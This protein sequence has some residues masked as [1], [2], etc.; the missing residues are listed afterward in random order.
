LA[1]SRKRMQYEWAEE[2]A[3]LK[4]RVTE[5]NRQL[6]E[7]RRAITFPKIFQKVAETRLG[8]DVHGALMAETAQR[9]A[10]MDRETAVDS[11]DGAGSQED[12]RR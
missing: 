2:E 3:R 5:I 9:L 8:R 12:E 6:H 4:A 11:G 1:T 7:T 10:Q